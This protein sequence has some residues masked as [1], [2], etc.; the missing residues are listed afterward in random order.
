MYKIVEKLFMDG[1]FDRVGEVIGDFES[2]SPYMGGP[3]LKSKFHD[4]RRKSMEAKLP[5]DKKP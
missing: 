1:S 4:L 2:K 3:E 5:A